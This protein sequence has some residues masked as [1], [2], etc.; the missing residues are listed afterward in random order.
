ML[1]YAMP[2]VKDLVSQ[3]FGRLV[4]IARAENAGNGAVRWRC[5]C[6]CGNETVSWKK[7]LLSGRAKSCGCLQ[8]EKVKAIKLKHG[9]AGTKVWRTWQNAKNRV[10][11]VRPHQ[12]YPARGITMAPEW[13]S[14]FE[15]FYRDMGDPP[16]EA[17][18]IE[19]ID[20]N[21]NYEPGNCRWATRK[22]QAANRHRHN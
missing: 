18:T 5:R 10:R 6:D 12:N 22:E 11:Y 8:R 17:H 2:P 20:N 16:T 9:K 21:G 14:S 15:A 4:V 19:R 1:E 7:M 13:F 3:R